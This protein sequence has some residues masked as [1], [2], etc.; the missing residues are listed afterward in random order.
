[1]SSASPRESLLGFL[2]VQVQ[3]SRVRYVADYLT[4]SDVKSNF[5]ADLHSKPGQ[6]LA[7]DMWMLKLRRFEDVRDAFLALCQQLGV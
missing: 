2:D 1:M 4:A 6:V 5:I 3:E 7:A